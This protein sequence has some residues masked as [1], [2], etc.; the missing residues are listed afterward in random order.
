MGILYLYSVNIYTYFFGC[1]RDRSFL[2][3]DGAGFLD[4]ESME[5]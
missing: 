3:R 1:L 2:A 4:N 5:S